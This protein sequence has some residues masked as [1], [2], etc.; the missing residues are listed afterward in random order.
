MQL[1]VCGIE[2]V[3]QKYLVGIVGL[4]LI[5]LNNNLGWWCHPSSW[6]YVYREKIFLFWSGFCY[7][8]EV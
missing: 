4:F 8:F 5:F 7:Y 2:L 6:Y 3:E 1:F